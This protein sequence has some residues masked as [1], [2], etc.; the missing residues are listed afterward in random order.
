MQDISAAG[1]PDGASDKQLVTINGPQSLPGAQLP[2]SP[3]YPQNA[4]QHWVSPGPTPTMDSV[5]S[6]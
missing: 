3:S 4:Q 2:T 1:S 5:V 6:P